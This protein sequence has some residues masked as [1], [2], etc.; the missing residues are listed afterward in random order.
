[1]GV[2]AMRGKYHCRGIILIDTMISMMI[3][4]ILINIAYEGI[5]L[6]VQTVSVKAEQMT[7]IINGI[8][9]I[10]SSFDSSYDALAL[11]KQTIENKVFYYIC[12]KET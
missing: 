1:M 5:K 4:S 3:I 11:C 12:G 9:T 6:N 10:E 2:L 8:T 7:Q